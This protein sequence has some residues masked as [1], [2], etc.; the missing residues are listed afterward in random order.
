MDRVIVEL[1][2]AMNMKSM[3]DKAGRLSDRDRA[4]Q[5]L[6]R[7]YVLR[8]QTIETAEET[9]AELQRQHLAV[10]KKSAMLET[11][12]AKT[13]AARLRKEKMR[14]EENSALLKENTELSRQN[15]HLKLELRDM[16]RVRARN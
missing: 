7:G 14:L 13:E 16:R 15:N 8:T 10:E 6:Y 3:P 9:E 12:V 1:D 11:R 4:L 5:K 2:R